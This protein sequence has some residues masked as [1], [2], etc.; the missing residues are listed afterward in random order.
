M[1]SYRHE[2]LLENL[3]SPILQQHG[4]ADDNVPVF[5]SRRLFQLQSQVSLAA[6]KTAYV[7]L[8]GRGHWFDGK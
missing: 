7:E 3:D 8:E 1:S 4:S 5:H 2:I 6:D